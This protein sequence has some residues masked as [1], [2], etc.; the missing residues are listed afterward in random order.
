MRLEQNLDPRKTAVIINMLEKMVETKVWKMDRGLPCINN[1][2]KVCGEQK[3]TVDHLLAGCKM[4]AA[5]EYLN[6]HNRALMVLAVE[7]VKSKQLVDEG[8]IWYKE[9]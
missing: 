3:E 2:C 4:M 7:W 6:C 1:F 5:H 8:T 9:R